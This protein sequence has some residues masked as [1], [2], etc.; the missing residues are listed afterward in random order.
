MVG[1]PS[2]SY[3]PPSPLPSTNADLVAF[4]LCQ[5]AGVT[6]CVPL[7]AVLAFVCLVFGCG[8]LLLLDGFSLYNPDWPETPYELIENH[9]LLPTEGWLKRFMSR[10]FFKKLLS[11]SS[12]FCIG[13]GIRGLGEVWA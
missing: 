13:K 12:N 7:C 4:C 6:S 11:L 3:S 5:N 8:L 2:P 1:G 9:L 10:M